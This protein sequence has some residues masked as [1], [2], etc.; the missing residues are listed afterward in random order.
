MNEN[1]S[2]NAICLVKQNYRNISV[3]DIREIC[4]PEYA[5]DICQFAIHNTV[6]LNKPREDIYDVISLSKICIYEHYYV[7]NYMCTSRQT[8][9]ALDMRL[10]S[11]RKE[12]SNTQTFAFN[13]IT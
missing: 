9:H 2:V 6:W 1:L 4:K 10:L 7:V 8:F 13:L 11:E 3:C 5:T 12:H